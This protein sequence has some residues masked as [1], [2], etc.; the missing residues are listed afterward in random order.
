MFITDEWISDRTCRCPAEKWGHGTWDNSDLT[1]SER[2]AAQPPSCLACNKWHKSRVYSCANC[3]NQY[4]NWFAHPANGY[5]PNKGFYCYFC[6]ES[7]HPMG[8]SWTYAQS[9]GWLESKARIK[10]PP[11]DTIVSP[12]HIGVKKPTYDP[13]TQARLDKFRE[14]LKG[15]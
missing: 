3:K 14:F 4:V 8:V 7:L 10:I 5:Y 13:E 9:R 6:L 12:T 1:L 2:L 15:I 11:S